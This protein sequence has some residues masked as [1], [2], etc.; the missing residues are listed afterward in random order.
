MHRTISFDTGIVLDGE[1]V[2]VLDDGV[3]TVCKKH[4][5]IVQRGTIH[6][7]KNVGKET[8]RMFF[9]LTPSEKLKIGGEV[10]EATMIDPSTLYD[11]KEG[12]K[13]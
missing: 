10:L 4:D 13:L 1:V 11:E 3:E 8:V 5:I 7:W 9:M 2:M 6:A 12:T